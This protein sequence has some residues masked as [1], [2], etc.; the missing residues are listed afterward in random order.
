MNRTSRCNMM[1]NICSFHIYSTIQIL[2]EIAFKQKSLS[3]TQ[4]CFC[5]IVWLIRNA[6]EVRM[7]NMYIL[8]NQ[9]TASKLPATSQI[10]LDLQ[11][12]FSPPIQI[13]PMYSMQTQALK[14][15]TN[16]NSICNTRIIGASFRPPV[17]T[18]I[19]WTLWSGFH[20]PFMSRPGR[21]NSSNSA[22][23]LSW[24]L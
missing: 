18:C 15:L 19:L 20:V 13:K 22:W 16:I 14:I 23:R 8:C 7:C 21:E 11:V 24:L 3:H 17:V 2:P 6:L 9:W 10:T 1:G 4:T 12:L 5:W